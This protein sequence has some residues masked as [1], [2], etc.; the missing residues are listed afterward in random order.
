LARI[1]ELAPAKE[2][3]GQHRGAAL[4][5]PA[6]GEQGAGDT[7]RPELLAPENAQRRD[8]S[9][10]SSQ[11]LPFTPQP[12][13]EPGGERLAIPEAQR[14]QLFRQRGRDRKSDSLGRQQASHAI[15]DPRAILFDGLQ[16]SLEVPRIFRRDTRYVDDAPRM[17]FTGQIPR[18]Q[19]EEAVQVD[20]V[21][22]RP[23]RSSLDF[24]ARR[25]H[26]QILDTVGDQ[27][28]MEPEPFTT[29]L[30]ATHDRNIRRQA[31]APF[32]RRDLSLEPLDIPC[33][34]LATASSL[35]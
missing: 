1:P 3:A 27:P 21:G 10:Q 15:H 23:P 9:L 30:V 26:D 33:R 4:A 5:N 16:F 24:D 14:D 34:N 8:P 20:A 2:L 12:S 13:M 25:I 17:T 22:L 18:Q 32:R 29:G 11:L 6:Q 31:K 28:P 35:S 7:I 19:A